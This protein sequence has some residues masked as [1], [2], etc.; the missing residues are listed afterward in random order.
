MLRG[1][2]IQ[3]SIH[4]TQVFSIHEHIVLTLSL[5]F[6]SNAGG[7]FV[8]HTTSKFVITQRCASTLQAHCMGV[9]LQ[10]SSRMSDRSG[11]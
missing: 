10:A 1:H 3:E 6:T 9:G 11:S 7:F 5:S 4:V 2:E 8:E